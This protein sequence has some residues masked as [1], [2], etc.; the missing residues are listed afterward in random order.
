MSNKPII[1]LALLL[2]ASTALAIAP[3]YSIRSQ[4]RNA[5]REIAGA[6]WNTNINL[7]GMEENYANFS[8]AFEYTRSFKSCHMAQALFGC[9]SNGSCCNSCCNDS[10]GSNCGSGCN[11]CCGCNSCCNDCCCD[12]YQIKVSGSQVENR[13][14]CDWLA[15]YFCLPTDFQSCVTFCPRIENYIVDLNLYVGLDKWCP[16]TYFRIDAPVVHTRWD[17]NMCECV[18]SKGENNHW[19]GYYNNKL[20][21]VGTT[22]FGV[23]R[24]KLGSSFTSWAQGNCCCNIPEVTVNPLCYSK[25]DCCHRKE[26]AIAELTMALGWNRWCE[27]DYHAG[28]NIRASVPTGNRPNGC[29]LFEPIVGN[30]KHWELGLG[31]TSHWTCWQSDSEECGLGFYLD[32]NVTH[33]FKTCQCR[34]FDLKCKPLSRYM[35]AAKFQNPVEGGLHAVDGNGDSV[36]PIKQFAGVYTP[37]ANLTHMQV[38]VSVGAQLDLVFLMQYIYNNCSMG[39]GYNFWTRS[40]EKIHCNSDCGPCFQNDT[41]ALKG[42]AFMYGFKLDDILQE[43]GVALSATQSQATLYGGKNNYPDGDTTAGIKWAQN[44]GIDNKRKAES[45]GANLYVYTNPT[46]DGTTAQVYTSLEPIFI[47]FCDIDFC[48]A[49]TKALSHKVFGNIDYSFEECAGKFMCGDDVLPYLGIGFEA[50]FGKNPCDCCCNDCCGG[51]NSCCNDSCGSCNSCC[52]TCVGACG[53]CGTCCDD[54]CCPDCC[55]WIPLTQ[56]GVWLEGGIVF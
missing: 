2:S 18:G 30:G 24:E 42:D 51:C 33:L 12:C 50:E 23:L 10:C 40:C 45:D 55:Q 20:E 37:V 1:C 41:W 8:L 25:M 28:F 44:P 34:N 31:F 17:L 26:T 9:Q 22:T 53:T 11:D 32:A 15:D 13:C 21:A 14:P 43:P 16:C 48:G 49:R 5:A 4:G 39:I 3:Y 19:A 47:K 54:C 46:V 52:N 36:T 35:L 56:W 27:E 6:G 38:D 29:Y 7:C